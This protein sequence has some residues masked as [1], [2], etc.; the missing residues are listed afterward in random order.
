MRRLLPLL[1]I[2]VLIG[3]DPARPGAEFADDEEIRVLGPIVTVVRD[4]ENPRHYIIE[5]RPEP[6]GHA[7][8][9]VSGDQP[10]RWLSPP[11]DELEVTENHGLVTFELLLEDPLTTD[12]L[13][14]AF[15]YFDTEG[16]PVIMLREPLPHA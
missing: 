9:S 16:Q 5:F 1:P 4:Q 8:L 6:A 15:D 2:F 7:R 12:P 3:C 13:T 10:F 11:P 14:L